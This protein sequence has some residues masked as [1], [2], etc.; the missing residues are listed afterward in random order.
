[1]QYEKDSCYGFCAAVCGGAD[2]WKDKASG[3]NIGQYGGAA[4][5][6]GEVVG[7]G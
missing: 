1:M 6:S 4:E 7:M 3:N 5:G 2:A